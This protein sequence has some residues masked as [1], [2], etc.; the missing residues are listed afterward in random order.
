MIENLKKMPTDVINK[1][2]SYY[3]SPQSKELLDDIKNYT[4]SL[5]VIEK[6]Y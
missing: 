2:F 3:Y 5:K 1:I 6:I 4:K